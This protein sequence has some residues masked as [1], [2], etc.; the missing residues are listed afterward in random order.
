MPTVIVRSLPGRLGTLLVGVLVGLAVLTV[1]LSDGV[2]NGLRAAAWGGLLLLAVWA[3]WWAPELRL[4]EEGLTIRNAWRTHVLV[5]DAVSGCRTRWGLEVLTH[6]GGAVRAAAAPR[7][8]GMAISSRRRAEM[9][10]R[11]R[12]R[13]SGA[14]T[15]H[16]SQVQRVVRSEYLEPGDGVYRTGLDSDGAGDLIEAYARSRV[17]RAEPATAAGPVIHARWNRGPAVVGCA[18]AVLLAALALT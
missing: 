17:E 18:L 6:E 3:L 13:R 1:W 7:P 2:P 10:E 16:D 9:K 4:E 14:S 5:W 12:S 11:T 8:G 15:A